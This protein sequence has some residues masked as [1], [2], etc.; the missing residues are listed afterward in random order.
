MKDAAIL[1]VPSDTPEAMTMATRKVAGVPLIVR[2]IMT[3]AQAG[4]EKCVLLIAASQK[5]SIEKFLPRYSKQYVP[6]IKYIYY[7]E[8]YRVSPATAEE[9]GRHFS[10][11]CILVNANF[12]FEKELIE[13]TLR[14]CGNNVSETARRLGVTR[15]ILR[16]RMKKYDIGRID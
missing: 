2:G 11:R 10:E 9:I 4:I 13:Q 5:N 6:E 1:Y 14:A 7:D 12:L 15:D 3:L 16:Y 8:P